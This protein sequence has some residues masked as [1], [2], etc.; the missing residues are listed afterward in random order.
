MK[1]SRPN[2]VTDERGIRWVVSPGDPFNKQLLYLKAK[3]YTKQ[4]LTRAR[5]RGT[6]VGEVPLPSGAFPAGVRLWECETRLRDGGF[7]I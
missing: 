1:L 4:V 7:G 2:F 5:I 3:G 6:L